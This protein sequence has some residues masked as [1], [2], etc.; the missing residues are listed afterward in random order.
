MNN[1]LLGFSLLEPLISVVIISAIL[2]ISVFTV[3]NLTTNSITSN[4]KSKAWIVLQDYH[5]RTVSEHKLWDEKDKFKGFIIE[6]S[7]NKY[8]NYDGL[9]QLNYVVYSINEKKI[10]AFSTLVDE[11]LEK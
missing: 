2:S 5:K 4:L 11:Y 1:K 6:K 10:L 3:N 7:I 8:E 9:V